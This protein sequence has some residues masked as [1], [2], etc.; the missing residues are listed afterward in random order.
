MSRPLYQQSAGFWASKN[1]GLA[2]KKRKEKER[3]KKPNY[4]SLTVGWKRNT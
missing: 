1:G 2:G 4:L 3:E